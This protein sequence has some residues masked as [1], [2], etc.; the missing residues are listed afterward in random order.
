[1]SFKK[2]I[3]LPLVVVKKI[4]D[5]AMLL[6]KKITEIAASLLQR[7]ITA[8][9]ISKWQRIIEKEFIKGNI[10]LPTLKIDYADFDNFKKQAASIPGMQEK[11]KIIEKNKPRAY[12]EVGPNEKAKSN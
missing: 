9:K 7:Y 1:M 5:K 6:L 8:I 3:G 11:L 12:R 4:K 2:I 10:I